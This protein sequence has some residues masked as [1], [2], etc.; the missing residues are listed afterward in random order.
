MPRL[1]ALAQLPAQQQPLQ[2]RR[3]ESQANLEQAWTSISGGELA[4]GVR[5]RQT[6]GEAP[7]V[8]GFVPGQAQSRVLDGCSAYPSATAATKQQK[9]RSI[10]APSSSLVRSLRNSRASLLQ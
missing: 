4:A 5:L 8:V 2:Q 10:P 3:Q 1:S 9:A 7:T 6:S